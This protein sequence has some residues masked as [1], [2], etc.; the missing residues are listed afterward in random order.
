MPKRFSRDAAET[1]AVQALTFLAS[2]EERLTRFLALS[3]LAVGDLRDAASQPDFLRE[4]LVH[5]LEE[6]QTLLAFAD[7]LAMKPQEIVSAA[8]TLGAMQWERDIP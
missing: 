7:E 1:I 6:E 5:L 8:R 4:V 2:D 3:G